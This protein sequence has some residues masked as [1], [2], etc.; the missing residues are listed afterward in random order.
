MARHLSWNVKSDLNA[1]ALHHTVL[2]DCTGTK[3]TLALMGA[4][5]GSVGGP[6]PRIDGCWGISSDVETCWAGTAMDLGSGTGCLDA[7]TGSSVLIAPDP[8]R[9]G[10]MWKL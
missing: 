3:A 6:W 2:I 4:K 10:F 1:I 8:R 9:G 7:L 5:L